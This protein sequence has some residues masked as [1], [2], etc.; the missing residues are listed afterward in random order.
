M[1]CCAPAIGGGRRKPNSIFNN[2]S[3]E[4]IHDVTR[5]FDSVG[6]AACAALCILYGLAAR[7]GAAT[8]TI[9][10]DASQRMGAWNRYYEQLIATDHM[11]DMLHSA[12]GRNMQNAIKRGATECGFK[13]FRGHGILD[14]DIGLY[15]EPNGI[16]TYNWTKFDS[17]Y[18][19]AKVIGIR[20]IVEFN[21]TPVAMATGTATCLWYNGA[22]GNSPCLR[23]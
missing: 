20:P 18:D 7:A 23:T 10:V 1:L 8:Y 4:V 6:V 5:F 12:Y 14:A 15:S 19:A 11:H 13:Y 2:H 3:R 16:P 9:T 21:F 17:V 22:P